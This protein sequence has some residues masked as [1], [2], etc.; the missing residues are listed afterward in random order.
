MRVI[1]VRWPNSP[2]QAQMQRATS[3]VTHRIVSRAPCRITSMDAPCACL[4]E[5]HDFIRFAGGPCCIIPDSS[6]I[7][8]PSSRADPDCRCC[9]CSEEPAGTIFILLKTASN[10]SRAVLKQRAALVVA[11]TSASPA[12]AVLLQTGLP[13]IIC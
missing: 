5:A 12:M 8:R 7:N 9:Y 6:T 11:S 13:P 3:C 1:P 2:M 4:L 10:T